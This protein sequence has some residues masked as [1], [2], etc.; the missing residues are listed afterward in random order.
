MCEVRKWTYI[1]TTF[2]ML[3]ALDHARVSRAL[4]GFPPVAKVRNLS[5]YFSRKVPN[6]RPS[7]LRIKQSFTTC[8][9]LHSR[10]PY[11]PSFG[12]A[13]TVRTVRLTPDFSNRLRGKRKLPVRSRN[14]RYN[15]SVRR[16]EASAGKRS[17]ARVIMERFGKSRV[18]GIGIHSMTKLPL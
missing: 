8:S 11:F 6:V 14:H 5:Q 16:W 12:R 18:R 1:E 4:K 3:F 9:S 17:L 10:G 7:N 15:C 13:N 2:V